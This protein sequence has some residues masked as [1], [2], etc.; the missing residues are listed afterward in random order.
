MAKSKQLWGG[1][2]AV[3]CTLAGVIAPFVFGDWLRQNATI[4]TP[5]FWVAVAGGVISGIV[6]MLSKD[7]PVKEKE[8]SQDKSIRAG[9]DIGGDAVSGHKEEHHHHYP[10]E[11]PKEPEPTR[12]RPN[13]VISP[14]EPCFLV[15]NYQ[16]WEKDAGRRG[17]KPGA[18]FQVHNRPALTGGHTGDAREVSVSLTF[19]ERGVTLAIVPNACWLGHRESAV[20]IRNKEVHSVLVGIFNGPAEIQ[21]CDNKTPMD[22][23]I[24]IG[25]RPL[26]GPPIWKSNVSISNQWL[27]LMSL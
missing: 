22:T 5:I 26:P 25:R 8:S 4:L 12:P 23:G 3:T 10:P 15:F 13:L 24:W 11:S 1:V 19:K 14:P 7:V 2:L 9:R 21:L 17:G 27:R 20:N 6:L 18:I 16:H